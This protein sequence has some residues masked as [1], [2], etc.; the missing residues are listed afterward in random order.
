MIDA[1]KNR[2]AFEPRRYFQQDPCEILDRCGPPKTRIILPHTLI[3]GI[4]EMHEY[5]A[6]SLSKVA[7]EIENH[8]MDFLIRFPLACCALPV[9]EAQIADQI[10][11]N[12]PY[13]LTIMDGHHRKR[14][15]EEKGITEFPIEL[16]SIVQASRFFQHRDRPDYTHKV[17]TEWLSNAEHKATFA[18]FNQVVF[19]NLNDKL[20]VRVL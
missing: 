16:Y 8:G 2:F 15:G 12:T 9:N 6:S 18:Q 7:R 17:L 3:Y 1:V 20:Q 11:S 4:Q 5:S 14:I 19:E 13:I 10:F